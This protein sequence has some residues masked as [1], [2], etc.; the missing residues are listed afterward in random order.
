M[1]VSPQHALLVQPAL[2]CGHSRCRQALPNQRCTPSPLRVSVRRW[3][4]AT[5]TAGAILAAH[6]RGHR[7]KRRPLQA[8]IIVAATAAE[9]AVR[10]SLD[11]DRRPARDPCVVDEVRGDFPALQAEAHRGVPLVYLDSAA[12]SQKPRCV[13]DA[14]NHYYETSANVHRG[15]YSMAERATE[16]FEAARDSVARLIGASSPLEVV[17][18]SGATDAINLVVGSWG[19][20]NLGTGDEVVLTSMEHHSNLVPW[21]LAALRTGLVLKYAR[22]TQDGELDVEHLESLL[23]ART[24]LV[25]FT[26]VSNVLGCINPVRRIAEA[27]HRVG[28]R[29]LLDACQSVPHLPM[30]VQELGV[31]WIAASGHKMCAPTGIGFLWGPQDLLRQMP[32]WKGGGEM[33]EQVT[34]EGSTYADIPARFEAGTPPIAQAIGLGRACEYLMSIGMDRIEAYERE[35]S[36]HLWDSMASIE[37]LRLYGPPPALAE[38]AA[39]VAFND[40]REGV[41][42]ADIALTVD[43]DGYAIRA[44]HHC[45]Q[46]LHSQVLGEPF[47]TARVSLSFYNTH[48]DVDGFVSSLREN[49]E[50]LRAGEGCVFDPENP[51]ACYCSSARMRS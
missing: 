31:D 23:T 40:T 36:Q 12:T 51:E 24:K 11:I 16:A 13:L 33:I 21:Q 28:A 5:L 9:V 4:Q 19:V 1:Q 29:V 39:L 46:P 26:H 20:A 49:L 47:G 22:I 2:T 34:F 45:A 32:P 50:M 10:P 7:C 25:A 8:R 15:A 35:L 38:R 18:T 27:A 30:N 43:S 48:A 17:F 14:L 41:Y 3:R 42:P 6:C 44:G 37:G